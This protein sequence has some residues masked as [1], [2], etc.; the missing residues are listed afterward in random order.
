MLNEFYIYI[1]ENAAEIKSYVETTFTLDQF[2]DYYD[3]IE[4]LF[5]ARTKEENCDNFTEIL[6][7]FG[8]DFIN[9]QDEV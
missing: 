2:N 1:N 3:M 9:M 8:I 4:F 6:D 7:A 5:I